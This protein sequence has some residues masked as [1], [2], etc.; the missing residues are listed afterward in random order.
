MTDYDATIFAPVDLVP[1]ALDVYT[2]AYRV[3]GRAMTR[4]ARVA[5]IANQAA[6]THLHVEQATLSEYADPTATISAMQLLVN[7]E[8]ALLVITADSDAPQRPEM[9]IPKRSVRAQ[10]AVP[11]FRLT[12]MVHVPTGS[13]PADGVLNATDRFLTMTEATI[14]CAPHPELGRTATAI[15]FQRGRAQMILVAD[16]ENPDQLLADVLDAATAER[17]L[18]AREQEPL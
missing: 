17:W 9:R 2:D 12:G 7:M 5:D 14:A 1:V 6:N 18:H 4:F 16:D 3:S 15:A 10:I 8:A 11:P 13:R